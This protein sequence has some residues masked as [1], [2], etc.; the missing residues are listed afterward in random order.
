[1]I[2][3][4][5]ITVERIDGSII[6]MSDFK[7]KTLLI[8]NTASRCGFTGQYNALERVYQRYQDQ[9]FIVLAFPS[10][11]FMGQEPGSNAEIA[12]FCENRFQISFPLFSKIDVKGKQQHPL[13]AW[14]TSKEHHPTFGGKITWN[15]NKFL[16]SPSG[17]V[18]ARFGSRQSPTD[19]SILTAIESALADTVYK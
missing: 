14:L 10:N 16:I 8:V 5:D 7:G 1:M 19:E 13:Y 11:N 15:F 9:D 4:Y 17:E 18:I 12:Q 3:L 2:H 6:P